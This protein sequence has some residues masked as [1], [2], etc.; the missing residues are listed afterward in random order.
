MSGGAEYESMAIHN[1]VAVFVAETNVE[2]HVVANLLSDSGI[3]AYA[4]EDVSP[5]GMFTLGTLDE[6]HRPK[7]F[8]SSEQREAA[9]EVIARYQT[10]AQSSVHASPSSCCY[11][12]GAACEPDA[13]KCPSCGQFLDDGDEEMRNHVNRHGVAA[14]SDRLM[15]F[16]YQATRRHCL[17]SRQSS[18]LGSSA[19]AAVMSISSGQIESI[20][21]SW[22]L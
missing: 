2:A 13:A 21:E 19:V 5:A 18:S 3:G 17:Y 15:P 14:E 11:F 16:E 22:V 6:I 10:N 4:V 12:C 8:V 20:W 1:P 7:V 9:R